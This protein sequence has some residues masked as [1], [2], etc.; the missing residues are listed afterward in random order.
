M[1]KYIFTPEMDKELHHT[2]RI[3]TDSKPRLQNLA[4]KFNMPRWALYQ[5]ALKIGAVT[6]SHQ[7][8]PWEDKEIKILEKYA[9]YAPLTIKKKLEKAG[10][11]RSMAS[12]VLKRKRMKLLSNLEGM[13]ACLCAEF[14]GIDLHWVLNYI[15]QGLLKAEIIRHDRQGKAN[16]FIREKDLRRFIINNPDLID[17]RKVE[18]FYFIELVAN[19]QVH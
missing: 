16:Y 10:F 19:G 3:N 6:S 1:A 7:K 15:R 12:I 2:Y 8:K 13:S 5:R 11:Q 17:L 4:K 14:L 9:R 18:K